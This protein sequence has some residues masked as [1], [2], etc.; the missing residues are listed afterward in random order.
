MGGSATSDNVSPLNLINIR[1]VAYGTSEL[2]DLRK[3]ENQ[4]ILDCPVEKQVDEEQ[5]VD[6][7]VQRVLSKLTK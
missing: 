2:A 3:S 1:R 5:L 6:L 4:E 7:L